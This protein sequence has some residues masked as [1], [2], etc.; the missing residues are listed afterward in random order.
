MKWN[1]S[2]TQKVIDRSNYADQEQSFFLNLWIKKDNPA[3]INPLSDYPR[4]DIT[5]IRVDEDWLLV[6]IQFI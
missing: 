2:T 5:N 3:W 1:L 4:S 6:R